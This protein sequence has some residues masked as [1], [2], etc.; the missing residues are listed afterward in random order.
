M[1]MPTDPA[2]GGAPAV[3]PRTDT[4]ATD[5]RPGPDQPTEHRHRP[6]AWIAV[7]AVLALGVVGVTVWAP[8]LQSDLDH[9]RD[10]TAAGSSRPRT[11]PRRS[12]SSARTSSALSTR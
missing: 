6:W 10:E 8:A 5:P 3:L 2:A 9:Q 4:R 12:I 1:T 11:P 7:C